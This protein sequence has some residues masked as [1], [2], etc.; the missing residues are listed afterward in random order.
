MM[1]SVRPTPEPEARPFRPS[2]ADG[3]ITGGALVTAIGF[4]AMWLPLGFLAVGVGMLLVGIRAARRE[5]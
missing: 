3:L 2:P 4:G 5:R 1:P